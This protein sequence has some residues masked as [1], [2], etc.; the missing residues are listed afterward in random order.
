MRRR[1]GVLW[2]VQCRARARLAWPGRVWARQVLASAV[3]VFAQGLYH[4]VQE[5]ERE[6]NDMVVQA[7][8]E[9]RWKWHDE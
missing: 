7:G 9:R 8:W 3:L 2:R 5:G 4:R 1:E 6:V